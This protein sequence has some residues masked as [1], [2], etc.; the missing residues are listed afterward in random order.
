L[1]THYIEEAEFLAIRA[2]CLGK[3][4]EPVTWLVLSGLALFFLS[5]QC[6]ALK[7]PEIDSIKG[8]GKWK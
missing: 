1:T 3:A 6:F 4:T 2:A 7:K 5:W 8:K